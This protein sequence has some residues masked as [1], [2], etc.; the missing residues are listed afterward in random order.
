MLLQLTALS[1]ELLHSQIVRQLIEKIINGDL[2]DGAELLSI[3]ALAREYH[4]SVNTV[5]VS[6]AAVDKVCQNILKPTAPHQKISF[7]EKGE[8][9]IECCHPTLSL[10]K[11]K[12]DNVGWI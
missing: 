8:H 7:A 10:K 4:V 6:R 11:I 2:S 5:F 3:R 1:E 12:N 9:F